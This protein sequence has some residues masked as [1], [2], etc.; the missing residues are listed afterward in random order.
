L[1]SDETK[2]YNDNN[3]PSLSKEGLVLR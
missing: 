1:Q 2:K 3:K